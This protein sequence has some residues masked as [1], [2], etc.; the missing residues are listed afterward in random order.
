MMRAIKWRCLDIPD[1]LEDDEE[2]LREDYN[3]VEGIELSPV[4][5]DD[6]QDP[7]L[8]AITRIVELH[9]EWWYNE[10]LRQLQNRK[11]VLTYEKMKPNEEGPVESVGQKGGDSSQQQRQVKA[12]RE[13]WRLKRIKNIKSLQQRSTI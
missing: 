12:I 4:D 13:I 6:H 11:V 9:T 7:S 8:G 10:K 5:W 2:V 1:Q 3:I